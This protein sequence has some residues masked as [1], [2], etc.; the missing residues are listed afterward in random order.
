MNTSK[1][2]FIKAY[3]VNQIFALVIQT[4]IGMVQQMDA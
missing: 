1:T 3:L 4:I 2:F